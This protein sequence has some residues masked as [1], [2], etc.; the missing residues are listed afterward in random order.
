MRLAAR[1]VVGVA[2]SVAL[3]AAPATAETVDVRDPA[4]DAATSPA[5]RGLDIT[6]ASFDNGIDR[7]Q[8]TIGFLALHRGD[9]VVSVAPRGGGGLRLVSHYRPDR[10]ARSFVLAGSFD[11][12][13]RSR[14][15]CRGLRVTWNHRAATARLTMPSGCLAHAEYGDLRFAVLAETSGSDTD[16]APGHGGDLGRTRWIARG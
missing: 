2:V 9:L 10:P 16:Y 13:A 5:G 14:V 11:D 6:R 12:L 1:L 7:V 8:V 3:L 15:A 4:G